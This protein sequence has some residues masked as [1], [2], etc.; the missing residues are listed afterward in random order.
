MSSS[1]RPASPSFDIA[2]DRKVSRDG[3]SHHD[4]HRDKHHSSDKH[5]GDKH[6]HP[7]E[8]EQVSGELKK[9]EKELKRRQDQLAEARRDL[10]RREQQ[11]SGSSSVQPTIA[12]EVGAL[13]ESAGDVDVAGERHKLAAVESKISELRGRLAHTSRENAEWERERRRQH[14]VLME[15]LLAERRQLEAAARERLGSARLVLEG[16]GGGGARGG[17]AGGGGLLA[18]PAPAAKPAVDTSD[19]LVLVI[20]L[21]RRADRLEAVQALDWDGVRVEKMAAVDGS[22]LSWDELV[23]RGVVHEEAAKQARW[24]ADEDVPT[25]CRETGSFSPHLTFGGVGCALSHRGA[26]ER[27]AAEPAA[28]RAHDWVLVL[29][30]DVCAVAGDF[31]RRVQE[32]LDALPATWQLCYLGY[33]ETGG[34]VPL[35]SEWAGGA[36]A[37]AEVHSDEGLTGLFG[38]LIRKSAARQLTA[39]QGDVF[40]LRHQVDVALS[41]RAWPAAT[42]FAVPAAKPLIG[43]PRSEDGACDT[44][45][46]TLGEK[47]AK[48]HGA[49]PEGMLTM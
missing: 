9:A 30:D 25:I 26:W 36:Q 41:R 27:L 14:S 47:G 5:H 34:D 33:H 2:D 7:P 49:L 29:E 44:D 19:W 42:R 16:G 11:P 6:K 39:P 37:A 17:T 23:D 46:Q 38:Y 15:E 1:K 22:S 18:L 28:A 35:A 43:A 4:K 40:P 45:V 32:V 21:D 13:K 12:K 24:A 20:N 48:A 8:Y 3:G 31:A 10:Q